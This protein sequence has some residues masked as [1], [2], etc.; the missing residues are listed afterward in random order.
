MVC[1]VTAA[2]VFGG[3]G[4]ARSLERRGD[5][6]G[7]ARNV[8]ISGQWSSAGGRGHT[9]GL[10]TEGGR[11][12]GKGEWAVDE[13]QGLRCSVTIEMSFAS[14]HGHRHFGMVVGEGYCSAQRIALDCELSRDQDTLDCGPQLRFHRQR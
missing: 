10:V 4:W 3:V 7:D 14:D 9:M 13:G 5:S 1:V 8:G 12:F 11:S 6:R 2:V